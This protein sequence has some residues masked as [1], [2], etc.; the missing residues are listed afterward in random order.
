MTILYDITLPLYS[1]QVVWP[2]DPSVEITPLSEISSGQPVNISLISLGSHTGTH[3][4]A[5]RHILDHGQGADQIWPEK[6]MGICQVLDLT[7]SEQVILPEGIK[8]AGFYPRIPRILFKTKNST[9]AGDQKFHRDYVSLSQEAAEWLIEKKSQLIG[10]DYLS[11]ESFDTSDYPVHRILL[12]QGVVLLEG[13]VLKH[14]PPGVYELICAPLK[15]IQGDGA[16]ARV[17]LKKPENH[18]ELNF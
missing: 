7:S 16:P 2:G 17:F 3:I 18:M 8:K 5:P 10:I 6:L 1:G 13:I 4:D 14:V 12:S 9:Y 11:I 15:I